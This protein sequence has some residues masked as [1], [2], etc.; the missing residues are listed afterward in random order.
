MKHLSFLFIL[1]LFSVYS[2]AN[3]IE[4]SNVGLTGQNTAEGFTLVQFD[5]SWENSW[6]ISVGPANWDAAWVFVKYR[7]NGNNWNHATISLTG[8]NAPGGS[9]L[10]VADDQ[11]GAFLFRS[12]D[13]TGDVNYSNV[14]LRW[15][16]AADGV[17]ENA[18]VD[19][20]VFA[21]EMVYVPEGEFSIG[22]GFG[23]D[24]IDEFYTLIQIGMFFLRRTYDVTSEAAITV[25]NTAGNLYYDATVNGGDQL[26]PVP[27]AFPKGFAAFYCMKYEVS[28]DQWIGFF[29]TLTQGQKT[30]LDVTGTDGKNSDDEFIR[31]AISWPDAGNATT[32]NPNVPMNY[33]RNT[34]VYAYLDWSGLRP[35]TELEFEK[36]CRGPLNPV[37]NEFAWGNSNIHALPYTVVNESAP[38]EQI[39]DPGSG[40]G[41]ANY[42]ETNGLTSGPKRCGIIAASAL[43]NNREETG[44]SYYGIMELSGNVYERA[45]T[46][47]NPE[48]RGFTGQHGDG[49][50]SGAGTANVPNW[51][52][53]NEGIG[54]RG[55]AYPNAIQFLFV[56]D[57]NDAANS[58]SGTNGRI[59]FRGVRTS[60]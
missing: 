60:D 47:G 28:Q 36:A 55:A 45:I 9:E 20:Q 37:P 39:T 58:F 18:L 48:G 8:N 29:N 2:F 16:Y 33:V 43:L 34:F 11:T 26:G 21:I 22:T 56:S 5:V 24:E 19:V 23:G 57:R 15:E 10:D 52:A 32:T 12:G 54:Y 31:N 4:V 46:V 3:N 27:A 38:N 42:Q 1:L 25:S 59:G 14:Q 51:P 50:I 44:G 7:V 40:V 49:T 13:G 41:N 53:G 35:M 17:D 30:V 6:R